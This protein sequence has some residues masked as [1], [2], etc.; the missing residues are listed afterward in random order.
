MLISKLMVLHFSRAKRIFPDSSFPLFTRSLPHSFFRDLGK[1][2]RIFRDQRSENPAEREGRTKRGP[3]E[4]KEGEK[5]KERE[6]GMKWSTAR[7]EFTDILEHARCANHECIICRRC[8]KN[9]VE[10]YRKYLRHR[11][12]RR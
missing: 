1:L 9:I 11:T 4:E 5:E 3:K 6:R 7:L 12:H 8:D 10:K 2:M